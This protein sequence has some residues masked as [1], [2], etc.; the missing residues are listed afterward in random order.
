MLNESR[1]AGDARL[2]R[3]S[4]PLTQALVPVFFQLVWR[5]SVYPHW[6]QP[7]SGCTSAS[8]LLLFQLLI[9]CK[10]ISQPVRTTKRQTNHTVLVH[11]PPLACL[12][13][14]SWNTMPPEFWLLSLL[15]SRHPSFRSVLLPSSLD[16]PVFS[17]CLAVLCVFSGRI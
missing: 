14:S 3:P 7:R 10:R 6:A 8:P 17:G 13:S 9:C 16:A 11:F 2:K 15:P 1:S 4:S 12:P 5:H